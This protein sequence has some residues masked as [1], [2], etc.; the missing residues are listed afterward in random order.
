MFSTNHTILSLL[1]SIQKALG[2]GHIASGIFLDFKKASDTVSC[3][4]LLGKLDHYGIKGIQN[5]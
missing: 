1:E 3:D 5:D 4:I 2:D